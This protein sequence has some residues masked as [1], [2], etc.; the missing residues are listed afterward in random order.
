[1][2]YQVSQNKP[3]VTSRLNYVPLCEKY[4]NKK[5]PYKYKNVSSRSQIDP[6]SLFRVKAIKECERE[7]CETKECKFTPNLQSLTAHF[8]PK[9]ACYFFVK[10]VT[11]SYILVS[12]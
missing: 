6:Q 1:M 2:T 5:T 3:L 7:K 8:L 11:L 9:I 4:Y 10:F 12:V